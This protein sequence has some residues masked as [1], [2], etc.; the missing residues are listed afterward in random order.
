MNKDIVIDII[1]TS[2]TNN[3]IIIKWLYYFINHT[4]NKRRGARLLILIDSYRLYMTIP[5]H[6]LVTKNK[7]VLFCLPPYSTYLTQPLDIGVFQL[8][9]HY[10]TD[11]IDKVVRL[12]DEKF[13]KFKFL[14]TFQSF[15]HQTFKPTT[16][17]HAFKST[18]LVPFDPDVVPDKIR[19]NKPKEQ[20]LP[21]ELPLL[22]L[23]HYTN[24]PLKDLLLLSSMDK[25]YREHMPN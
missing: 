2:F 15:R 12:G 10:H 22:L 16:I 6:N 3:D 21:F 25:S 24:V 9:K 7:I 20:K 23:S 1:E 11:A 5:F 13:G 4:K 17:C 8:F 14:A 19:E 18:G